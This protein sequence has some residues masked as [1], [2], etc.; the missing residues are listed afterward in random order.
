[1]T[2]VLAV[3]IGAVLC[4]AVRAESAA[5]YAGRTEVRVFVRELVERHGFVEKELMR[6]FERAKRQEAILKAVKMPPSGNKSWAEYRANFVNPERVQAGLRFW[7]KYRAALERAQHEFG[8]PGELVVAIIGIETFYGKRTGSWRVIDALSTLAFDYPPR[9]PFFRSQL[10]H[11]LLFAR[12]GQL[13]VL[14]VHGSYAGAIG[15]PQ[16]MPGSYRHYAVDFDGDGAL[17]LRGNAVDAIGSVANFLKQHGWR[18]G[19]PVLLDAEVNGS[20]LKTYTDGGLQPRHTLEELARAGARSLGV[21]PAEARAVLV[22]LATPRMPSDFRIGLHNFW[23]I[24]HYNRS[25]FYASAVVD[26]ARSL[27]A[28]TPR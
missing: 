6:V 18:S 14:S 10:E 3:L 19:E 24:T 9:A 7:E 12:D 4:S 11:F 28:A 20:D 13:D 23:V 16:F 25:A 26:L 5:S 22:E 2:R 17:D 8:V 15:I 27:R 1:M 21:A